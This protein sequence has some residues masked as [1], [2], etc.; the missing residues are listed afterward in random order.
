MNQE[1]KTR[2]ISALRSGE[3]E[4]GQ[5]YLCKDRKYCCLGVLADI[6]DDL[7]YDENQSGYMQIPNSISRLSSSL[8]MQFAAKYGISQRQDTFIIMNDTGSSF[9]EI[10]DYIEE[11]L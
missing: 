2:W 9:N 11:N 5:G 10:S 3:Y 4:Q 8:P 1:L 7:A 6:E